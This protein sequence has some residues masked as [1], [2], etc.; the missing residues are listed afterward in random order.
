MLCIAETDP[1]YESFADQSEGIVFYSVPHRGS[2]LPAYKLN[3]YF[4]L[5]SVE[6]QELKQGEQENLYHYHRKVSVE[7]F[8]NM[9]GLTL[10][11]LLNF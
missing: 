4:F 7:T 6:V 5:P 11:V 10:K 3:E 1:Q 8:D 2:P 9:K